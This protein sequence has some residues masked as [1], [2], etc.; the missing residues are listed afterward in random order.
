MAAKRA[1]QLPQRNQAWICSSTENN[2]MGN[3]RG[4][5]PPSISTYNCTDYLK[6]GLLGWQWTNPAHI[7]LTKPRLMGCACRECRQP[8]GPR[9]KLAKNLTKELFRQA[10]VTEV[11]EGQ[12]HL[13]SKRGRE[14]RDA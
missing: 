8:S 6:Q 14:I 2:P 9:G 10:Q 3:K 12:R 13:G 7:L 11:M 5:S 4:L 1:A